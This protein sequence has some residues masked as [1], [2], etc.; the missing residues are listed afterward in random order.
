MN[1]R[2]FFFPDPPREL[3]GE[4]ILRTTLRTI[5]L[6]AMGILLGGHVF[7]VD[8]PRLLPWLWL[9]IGTGGTFAALEMYGSCTW[10]FQVRGVLFLAK[11]A[12]LCLVPVFWE[13]RVWFLVAVLVI[14]SAGSHLPA[15][16]RCHSMLFRNLP[17]ADRRG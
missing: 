2:A 1:A 14:G 12:L 6:A 5:H 17:C 4:R 15:R 11:I 13:Q 9:T 10:L 8:A 3:R 7:G 16:F